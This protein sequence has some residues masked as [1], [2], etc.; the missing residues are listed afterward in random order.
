VFTKEKVIRD[1]KVR[2]PRLS[3]EELDARNAWLDKFYM[4]VARRREAA[5]Q[6]NL[7]RQ[8]ELTL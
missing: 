2:R 1:G 4:D 7:A 5:R 6:E 3:K 8:P